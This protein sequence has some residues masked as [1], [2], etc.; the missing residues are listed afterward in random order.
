MTKIQDDDFG[1]DDVV[2]TADEASF[3]GSSL[4]TEQEKS[5]IGDMMIIDPEPVPEPEVEPEP[6]P[7]P[8]PDPDPEPDPIVEKPDEKPAVEK[9]PVIEPDPGEDQIKQMADLAKL[10]GQ[11][12]KDLKAKL[13]TPEPKKEEEPTK[14]DKT[15][16]PESV[17][18]VASFIESVTKGVEYKET[19]YLKSD[20][21]PANLDTD[22]VLKINIAIN[23]AVQDA[24]NISRKQSLRDNMEVM[25][26]V[27]DRR[28]QTHLT[29]HMFWQD[30]PHLKK[31]TQDHPE[32]N[33][34]IR[35]KADSIQANNPNLN[36]R[37]VL[38]KTGKEIED[39]IK[40]TGNKTY[41]KGEQVESKVVGG[42]ASL[43]KKPGGSTN[44]TLP[45]K[46]GV[47]TESDE[48]S[49]MINFSDEFGV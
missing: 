48:I 30:N 21:F 37:Q 34:I 1:K 22:D 20:D 16:Q 12:D 33:N 6:E 8:V 47:Q 5:E 42:K 11:D 39:F 7:D 9:D 2:K 45:K 49:E 26:K 15:A 28:I 24:L 38:D 19:E 14:D 3:D 46:V 17:D 10:F 36:Q 41:I 43:P 25:P 27:Y 29:A 32:W 44:R 4:T 18:N 31:L 13:D 35:K 23:K 40:T